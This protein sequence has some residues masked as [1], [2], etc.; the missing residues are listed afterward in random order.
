[1]KNNISTKYRTKIAP[2][3]KTYSTIDHKAYVFYRENSDLVTRQL[4]ENYVDYGKMMTLFY[5]IAE[6]KLTDNLSGVYLDGL[7]YFGVCRYY[8]SLKIK[9]WYLKKESK[10]NHSETFFLS[11]V[12]I[13]TRVIDRI[14]TMDLSFTKIIRKRL[15]QRIRE[16]FS[17]MFNPSV[18]YYK[19]SKN[20][21]KKISS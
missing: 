1:M 20:D 15:T 2:D 8:N 13:S 21:K 6:E 16:G 19:L 14:Y 7:G 9:P 18:F 5:R 17:Y 10:L 3:L 12:P 4:V 11:Y